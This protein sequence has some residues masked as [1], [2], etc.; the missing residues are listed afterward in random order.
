VSR[1]TTSLPVAEAAAPSEGQRTS[2]AHPGNS[3]A[4]LADARQGGYAHGAAVNR[5]VPPF[6]CRMASLAVHSGR[7]PPVR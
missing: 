1:R 4:I 3:L 2:Q 5:H 7:P 6:V